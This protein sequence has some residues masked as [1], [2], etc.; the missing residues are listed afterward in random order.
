MPSQRLQVFTRDQNKK[1][2]LKQRNTQIVEY[3]HFQVV[4]RL[5]RTDPQLQQSF[6]QHPVEQILSTLFEDRIFRQ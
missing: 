4:E 5:V 6:D 1:E 3:E 2:P